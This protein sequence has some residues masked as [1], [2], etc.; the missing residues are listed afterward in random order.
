MIY[1]LIFKSCLEFYF[2]V[3]WGYCRI[4]KNWV[5]IKWSYLF[6]LK[7][8]FIF[9]LNSILILWIHFF[10]NWETRLQNV[11][12]SNW[13]TRTIHFGCWDNIWFSNLIP[14]CNCL[15]CWLI[16]FFFFNNRINRIFLCI[17]LLSLL[18][19]IKR[20]SNLRT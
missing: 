18:D 9:F 6:L 4:F 10:I 19:L 5:V 7:L 8:L 13:K 2:L 12:S 20:K 1:K 14:N 17:I 16:N 15:V 11:G 3:M